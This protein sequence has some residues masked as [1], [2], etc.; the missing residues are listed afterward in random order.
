MKGLI[1]AVILTTLVLTGWVFA[2]TNIGQII[3]NFFSSVV[4]PADITRTNLEVNKEYHLFDINITGVGNNSWFTIKILNSTGIV[5]EFRVKAGPNYVRNSWLSNQTLNFS[6]ASG[7][8]AGGQILE[9][10]VSSKDVGQ[11]V[12]NYITDCNY[13][14]ITKNNFTEFY[15]GNT[16]R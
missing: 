14:N 16:T 4:I 15:N 1:V 9:F 6:V 13:C 8:L 2:E 3:V 5:P 10:Y 12:L 7:E 11:G